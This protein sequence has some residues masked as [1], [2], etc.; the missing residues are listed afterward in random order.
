MKIVLRCPNLG[1]IGPADEL[2]FR[3]GTC[4]LDV[5]A[6]ELARIVGWIDANPSISVDVLAAD[7]RPLFSEESAGRPER[8]GPAGWAPTYQP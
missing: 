4:E 1:H 5:T 6:D 8:P 7:G 2:T 3:N